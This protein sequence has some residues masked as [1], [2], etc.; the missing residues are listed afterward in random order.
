MLDQLLAATGQAGAVP[1]NTIQLSPEEMQAI[2]RLAELGFPR[3]ACVEAY[4]A[5]DKDEQLAANLLFTNPPE[6]EEGP[7]PPPANPSNNNN[8]NNSSAGSGGNSAGDNAEGDI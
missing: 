2:D 1:R 4:L 3:N 7:P 6:E 5:C 8:N